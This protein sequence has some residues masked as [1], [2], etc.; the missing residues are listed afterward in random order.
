MLTSEPP[1][2]RMNA[3]TRS[4]V[5]LKTRPVTLPVVSFLAT[6]SSWSQSL[7]MSASVRPAFVHRSVLISSASVEKSFGTQ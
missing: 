5:S 6:V 3:S 4:S 7:G 1:A 2:C